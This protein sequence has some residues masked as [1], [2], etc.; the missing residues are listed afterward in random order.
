MLL[1]ALLRGLPAGNERLPFFLP[2]FLPP[3][4][5]IPL[6]QL[7]LLFLG[8]VLE[9]IKLVVMEGN[10]SC[11]FPRLLAISTQT[12]LVR[13]IPSTR[14]IGFKI[15]PPLLCGVCKNWARG[16]QESECILKVDAIVSIILTY[17][18]HSSKDRWTNHLEG[19]KEVSDLCPIIWDLNWNML[20]TLS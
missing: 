6:R 12:T 3:L 19:I 9:F 5:L 1:L 7:L 15:I 13:F 14:D 8:Q 10:S 4:C 17:C 2:Y 20:N 11:T 18:S 16:C